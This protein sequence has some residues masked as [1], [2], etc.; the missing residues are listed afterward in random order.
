[1]TDEQRG[2]AWYRRQLMSDAERQ[3]RFEFL[4][5]RQAGVGASD[6]PR[7]FT[8]EAVEVYHEKTRPITLEDIDDAETSIDLFRGVLLEPIAVRLYFRLTGLRGQHEQKQVF[9]PD[10]PG[11]M[12]SPDGTIFA[13][14]ERGTGTLE[15]KAPGWRK[16]RDLAQLGTT[17]QIIWQLQHSIAVRRMAWGAYVFATVEHHDGPIIPVDIDAQTDLGI[18]FLE[19]SAEFYTKHV[20]TRTPPNA[21][22]WARLLEKAP[23]IRER[24]ERSDTLFVLDREQDEEARQ[25][26]AQRCEVDT[27]IRQAKDAQEDLT[28][29]L[30][31]L[32]TTAYPG[33]SKFH[34]PGIAKCTRVGS[35]TAGGFDRALLESHR[36]V[37]RDALVRKMME[38][39][40]TAE[41]AERFIEG[42]D[43]DL[44]QFQRAGREYEYLRL[45]PAKTK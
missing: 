2:G 33:R 15:A 41:E 45:T 5:N 39:G 14:P 20:Q 26:I 13:T 25:L 27:L 31:A 28:A 17:E 38:G 37:D 11:A 23:R 24:P 34:A 1:V 9:H 8:G 4:T 32:L 10:Y 44:T 22:E 21:A 6:L 42:L 18:F 35:R 12:C 19:T 40:S 3:Q 29:E 30:E 16:F 36:P 43:L 7:I